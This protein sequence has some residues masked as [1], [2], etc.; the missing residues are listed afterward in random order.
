MVEYHEEELAMAHGY[1]G[2]ILHFDLTNR[3][4]EVKDKDDTFYRSSLGGRGVGYHYLV[5]EETRGS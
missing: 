1:R 5:K 3:K 4:V 2:K